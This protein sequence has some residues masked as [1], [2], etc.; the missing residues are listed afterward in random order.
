[1]VHGALHLRGF[2]HDAPGE[3]R[4]METRLLHRLGIPNPWRSP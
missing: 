1:V 4:R 3:A 2:L